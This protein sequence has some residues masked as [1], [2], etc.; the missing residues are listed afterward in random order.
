MGILVEAAFAVAI[1]GICA[2]YMWLSPMARSTR[3]LARLN[4]IWQHFNENTRTIK[5]IEQMLAQREWRY[6]RDKVE[7]L[8]TFLV[9]FGPNR[10]IV[11]RAS[12]RV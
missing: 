9:I 4:R 2:W 1:L 5:Q 10:I 12:N 6:H 3:E 7:L 8:K 11:D